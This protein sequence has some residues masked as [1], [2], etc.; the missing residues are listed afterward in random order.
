MK[1]KL[2]RRLTKKKNNNPIMSKKILDMAQKKDLKV[3]NDSNDSAVQKELKKIIESITKDFGEGTATLLG[4]NNLQNQEVLST[5]SFLLDQAIGTGGYVHGKIIEIFGLQSS[6]KSTLSLH[7]VRECQKLGKKAVYFDLEN[8]LNVKYSEDIGVKT[9]ELI[10]P[11]P[12]SGEEVFDMISRLIKEKIDLIIVDSVSNLIPRAQLEASLEKQRVGSHASLMSSGLRRL[13]SEL[14]NQHT[15]II[16]INQVRKNISTG[17]YA[18]SPEVTTGG[19][20]LNFDSDL[21]I[22]LKFKEKLEKD[23]E[24]IGIKVEA[25]IV[26]NKLAKPDAIVN[27]EIIY[28]SGIQKRREIL[29]LAVEKNIIQKSGN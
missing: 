18:G 6:G 20:A 13:K 3:E 21:R 15:I 22:K 25:K 24:T 8:S 10:V 16:F 7:A 26:K 9:N 17:F 14:T 12:S 23:N 4:E 19:M 27:L 29:D 2:Q 11:Y 28:S 1:K 5:G